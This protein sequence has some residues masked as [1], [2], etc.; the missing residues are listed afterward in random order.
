MKPR[1]LCIAM[2][3]SSACITGVCVLVSNST[4]A[5]ADHRDWYNN[6]R[7]DLLSLA[8]NR[9]ENVPPGE[10]E[11]LIGWTL[12]LHDNTAS[13]PGHL[14]LIRAK[15]FSVELRRLKT[16]TL[17]LQDIDWIWDQYAEFT[18]DGRLYGQRYRPTLSPRANASNFP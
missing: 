5:V 18:T 3:I 10:W 7:L 13:L 14:D 1:T 8:S 11:F 16:C 9:S 12:N 4:V 2:V 17:G 15:K 6:T